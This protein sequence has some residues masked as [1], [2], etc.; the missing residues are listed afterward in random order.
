MLS[1][2]SPVN[3]AGQSV[4]PLLVQWLW[5]M[6]FCMHAVHVC[7]ALPC[8]HAYVLFDML[9]YDM[10]LYDI[11]AD[12]RH[13]K[14]LFKKQFQLSGSYRRQVSRRVLLLTTFSPQRRLRPL[15]CIAA[16]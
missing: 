4:R 15:R 8:M 13:H 10:L 1:L 9:L 5:Y 16:L 2:H 12:V 3:T 11:T 6:R 14:S 7:H